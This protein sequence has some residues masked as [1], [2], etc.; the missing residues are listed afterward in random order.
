[1]YIQVPGMNNKL[2]CCLVD[3]VAQICVLTQRLIDKE[4]VFRK[5][6]Q[7]EKQLQHIEGSNN[8]KQYQIILQTNEGSNLLVE[9]N[10]VKDIVSKSP[11]AQS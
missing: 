5:D 11:T 10:V 3:C 9:A 1:M 8:S 2:K 4:A 7:E 6:L